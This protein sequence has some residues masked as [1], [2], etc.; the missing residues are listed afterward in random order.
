M[1]VDGRRVELALNGYQIRIGLDPFSF[2]ITRTDSGRLIME[3]ETEQV[4]GDFI[5]PPLGFR[6]A[7]KTSEP[8]LS[9][10]I[11]NSDRF[12]GLGEKFNKVEKSSTRA[13]IWSSDTAGTNTTDLVVQK[14]PAAPL[15]GRLESDAAHD[16]P[17]LLGDRHVLLHRRLLPLRR[18]TSWTPLSFSRR[19]SR[20]SSAGTRSSPDARPIPPLWAFGVW[21]SRC[22]Y[23]SRA[24]VE[25]VLTRL[26]AEQIPCDVVH[27]DPTWMRTH[28][29]FKL[30]VDAC[31]FV[32]K[33]RELPGLP[34]HARELEGAGVSPPASGSIPTCRK[35]S[36]SMKKPKPKVTFCARRTAASPG[37]NTA[38]RWAWSI[39]P[40]REAKAWWKG[41][42][43]GVDRRRR[44][45]VQARLRRPRVRGFPRL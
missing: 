21:M 15:H 36:R 43:E 18:T 45:G 25:T 33:R 42:L 20:A 34:R 32:K 44:R 13:T 29:Y 5:T 1:N 12:F 4:A 38:S 27:L 28:Y 23:T 10:R 37:S 19:R 31:D 9:W 40:T 2:A 6:R 16:L 17:L 22:A 26:R 30:G 24:Q 41:K 11:H 14:H 35:A 8:F 3:L 39:S 7:G